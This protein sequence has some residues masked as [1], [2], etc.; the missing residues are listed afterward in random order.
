MAGGLTLLSSVGCVEPRSGE[1]A[2]SWCL[3][4]DPLLYDVV[5][6]MEDGDG[7]TCDK[8][9]A[10]SVTGSG[11]LMPRPGALA[12]AADLPGDDLH[13]RRGSVRAMHLQGTTDAGGSASLFLSLNWLDLSPYEEIQ[14]WARSD[15]GTLQ[16]R[17]NVATSAT[18]ETVQGGSCDPGLGA[19]G[20]HYGDSPFEITEPWGA[21]GNPNSIA[22]A[23]IA[24][25]GFGQVVPR[26]FT[27]T[28]G[29]EFRVTAPAAAAT[30]FGFWIDD[31]Q[32]K[33]PPTP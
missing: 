8:S 21:A 14:F 31:V 25:A 20:D 5:D 16:L 11:T 27:Q 3:P 23:G 4:T 19:C 17:V 12:E 15:S 9:G 2:K 33:R 13:A 32:V 28:M 7:K 6:D 26:D 1:T 29:I 10:W 30:T 24:Q 18:T 22:L